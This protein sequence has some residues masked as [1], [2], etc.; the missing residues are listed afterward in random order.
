MSNNVNKRRKIFINKTFQGRFILNVLLLILLS[1]FSSAMLIYWVIGGDLQ[2]ESQTAHE[3]INN[4]L[5]HLGISLILGNLTAMLIVGMLTVF[6]VL[7]ASHKIAGPLYRFEKLCEQIG[8]GQLD[9]ISRLREGDQLQDMGKAFDDMIGKL[10]NRQDQRKLL[11]TKLSGQLEQLQQDQAI[12]THHSEHLE[13][14][15]QTLAQLQE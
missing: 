5:N 10:R 3:N 1:G 9:G 7:Y 2:V 12:A 13:Q 14:M 11:V 4:A 6:M 8:D 15:R